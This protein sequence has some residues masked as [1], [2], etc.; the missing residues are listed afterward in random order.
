MT[1][2]LP[3]MCGG[4]A[5]PRAGG[6]GEGGRRSDHGRGTLQPHEMLS[7]CK[8]LSDHTKKLPAKREHYVR[9]QGWSFVRLR[10]CRCQNS[11][12]G[13]GRQ[14]GQNFACFDHLSISNVLFVL[15][16]LQFAVKRRM[17]DEKRAWWKTSKTMIRL[18][19]WRGSLLPA[20]WEISPPPALAHLQHNV[21][22]VAGAMGFY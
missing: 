11:T 17:D 16:G 19:K 18:S 6:Q 12:L 8:L 20:P 2:R 14:M 22:A 9:L 4:A 10:H 1:S 13:G 5:A 7:F 3:L 15:V 21:G